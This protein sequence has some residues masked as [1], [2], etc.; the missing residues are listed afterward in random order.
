M[1]KTYMRVWLAGFLLAATM[2][3][4]AD[5]AQSSAQSGLFTI[6]N[7]M[8]AQLV[9]IDPDTG[10]QR[11]SPVVTIT[12]QY[13]NFTQ[14][15]GTTRVWLSQGAAVID[16]DSFS[17]SSDTSLTA[18]F[19]IDGAAA[20]G[21]WNVSVSSDI[22]GTLTLLDCFTITVN[23][24]PVLAGVGDKSVDEN[25]LLS[26]VV[27][28]SDPDND[29]LTFAADDLPAGATFDTDTFNWTPG[30]DQ[31]GSYEVTF[32]V[33]DYQYAS[34]ETIIITVINVGNGT[35]SLL[36]PNGGETLVGGTVYPVTWSSE[37][38]SDVVI[39]YSTD[40][41]TAWTPVSPPN[42]GN[43][44]GYDWTVPLLDSDRC[45][46]HVSDLS[47]PLVLDTSNGVFTMQVPG[48][49]AHWSFDDPA[50][51][52]H[53]DSG[54][55]YDGTVIGATW[56]SGMTG[57]A[58]EFDGNDD[59]V[60][61]PTSG[62]NVNDGTLSLWAYARDL[63]GLQF[64]FGHTA[65]SSN[66]M[67]L[68]C[69]AGN[70]ALGLGDNLTLRT[71]IQ[72]LNLNV[73]HHLALTWDGSDY[74]VY[75]DGIEAA[76]G[77]YSNFTTLNSYADIGNYGL[78]A[79]RDSA[80]NGIIDDVRIFGSSDAVFTINLPAVLTPIGN[81]T[82]DE[83]RLLSFTVSA[84][85][86]DGDGV[87]YS[88]QN[89]PAG[90]SFDPGS[91]LFSWRPGH[92]Q[93]G[94]YP[95]TFTVSDG[96]YT[97]S[98]TIIVTVNDNSAQGSAE[99][100]VFTIDNHN[101]PYIVSI[102]PDSARQGHSAAVTVI[103]RNT[104]FTQ[105]AGVGRLWLSLGYLTIDANTL[106]PSTD[107]SLTADFVID[108]GIA[109]GLW[110]V[111]V[112]SDVDGIV[113]LVRGFTVNVNYPPVLAAIGDKLVD[114]NQPLTFAISATDP[115]GDP[116]TY[117][118]VNLPAGATFINNTFTWIPDGNQA[119][120]YTITFTASDGDLTDSET[121]TVTV[122][123]I[124]Y[125]PVFTAIGSKLIDENQPLSFTVRA[126]DPDGD[127]IAYSVQN[128]PAGAIFSG[129]IFAWTPGYDQAGDHVITFIATDGVLEAVET[130]IITVNN[131][132][133]PPVLA[134]IGAQW[135]RENRPLSFTII[136]TDPEGDTVTYSA[137]DLPAGASFT[138]DTF[139]WTP[140]YDQ[141]GDHVIT[142]SASDGALTDSETITV[143]VKRYNG[144]PVLAAMA[145][146]SVDENR[147]ITFAVSASDPDG[148]PIVYS[149]NDLPE[150][151]TLDGDTFAW[152]P[153][154]GQQGTY[155]ITFTA[156]D[157]EL[158][159]SQT[160][161][162]TVNPVEMSEWYQEWLRH[163]GLLGS[164]EPEG[165]DW[166]DDMSEW[167]AEWLRH[168]GLLD[169]VE[170]ESW[171]E[172][173]NDNFESGWGN[174]TG[175]GIDCELY[176]GGTWA[177][178]GSSAANIQDNSEIES[179]F[180]NINGIDVETPG[181]TEIQI[182]FWF[183]ADG[184]DSGEDFLVEYYDGSSWHTVAAYAQGVDFENSRFYHET[185]YISETD[186]V[187]PSDMKIR[188]RCD[189]SSNYDDVYIDEIVVS[190]R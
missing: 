163:L 124:N 75:V 23:R 152:T 174:Y 104:N 45:L 138:V 39:E 129:G 52:G 17:P 119:G 113:R 123:N 16:A 161:T 14:G 27:S 78:A 99:S 168:L 133:G 114:E 155:Q 36:T 178:Q 146:R 44:G 112:S 166:P 117:T 67:Q 5:A 158:K 68:Y 156:S 47:N 176:T 153:W 41:G 13:S 130:I 35:L 177:Y 3:V 85:D 100:D 20:T 98:E 131:V 179:S 11:D 132:N 26:F 107:T 50:D 128:L 74:A 81:R 7:R 64:L 1:V 76:S 77:V 121:I 89:L 28:G 84:T 136:A 8:V 115:N 63:S 21:L 103:G 43:S 135:T 109:T 105:G 141:I 125:G 108:G 172:L 4:A 31:S 149:S 65:N 171:I 182:D 55:G 87:T 22:D 165:G 32:T 38:V 127:P 134:P 56:T 37:D 73:W 189:A 175:K 160:V 140:S 185:I 58:L 9:S 144:R 187:F 181:Y 19:T 143:A 102:D 57:G 154:Y 83:D 60:E 69:V 145:D 169:P 139:K 186:H 15:Y 30:G 126:T 40:N 42:T 184:M 101:Q 12:G 164:I 91:R 106:S 94:Q 159:V 157:G 6:D 116:M 95:V 33:S 53:D 24:P 18:Y 190:A 49:G 71:N 86:P 148:D 183:Y 92:N 62:L 48:A 170:P 142:F 72:S 137:Q 162:I 118:A 25:Q 151:A 96:Q 34:S 180:Y 70:L 188:F 90:A 61:I 97:D 79:S 46:L 10:R 2:S 167:Y 122:N 29:P 147:R 80:F 111:N 51:I 110:D 173:T 59:V 93:A 150:G 54:N 120:D 82:I 88:A 66:R